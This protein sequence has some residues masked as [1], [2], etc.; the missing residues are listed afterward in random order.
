MVALLQT[1]IPWSSVTTVERLNAWSSLVLQALDPT[2]T[3]EELP[4][5][6][7]LVASSA[8]YWITVDPNDFHWRLASRSSLRIAPA[9]TRTGKIWVHV[10]EITQLPI[11]AEFKQV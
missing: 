1:D 6:T 8:P 4:G 11:P 2:E 10:Q 7:E 3:V 5:V 9:W